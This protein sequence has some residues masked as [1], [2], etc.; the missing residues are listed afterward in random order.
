MIKLKEELFLNK[1]KGYYENKFN[2]INQKLNEM[3]YLKSCLKD[4]RNLD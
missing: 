3:I 1:I 2:D 4:F